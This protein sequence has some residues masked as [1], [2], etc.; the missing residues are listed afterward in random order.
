[1]GQ[2]LSSGKKR[3]LSSTISK[4][5]MAASAK[6][7]KVAEEQDLK[8]LEEQMQELLKQKEAAV[9]EVN[10]KWADAAADVSEIS[11]NPTKSNIFE[12]IFGV[13]WL[14]YYHTENAGTHI[15]IPAF[16]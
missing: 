9:Q 5:R 3:S 7:K 4:A 15:E 2:L 12:E 11:I 13:G 10:E 1:V 14:P 6:D 8:A 16:N